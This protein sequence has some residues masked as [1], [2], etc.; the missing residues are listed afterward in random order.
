MAH[1]GPNRLAA[2]VGVEA[3]DVQPKR[4]RSLPQVRI[5]EPCSV[6][7]QQVVHLPETALKRGGLGGACGGPG[8]G[9]RRANG[10]VAKHASQLAVGQPRAQR[11]AVRALEVRVLDQQRRVERTTRVIML[12]D[13]RDSR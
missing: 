1:P 10:E 11:G 7:E 4:P 2:P 6:D 9:M 8:A 5:L 13:L 3:L 12:G